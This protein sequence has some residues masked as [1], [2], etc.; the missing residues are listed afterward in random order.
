M[1]LLFA[2][3]LIPPFVLV[4]MV[5]LYFTHP[6]LLL[7]CSIAL[8]MVRVFEN[9]VVN[10][11]RF[12]GVLCM[13]DKMIYLL[14][15]R[16][17]AISF[18]TS[19]TFN[20]LL[21]IK[22]NKKD[23]VFFPLLSGISVSTLAYFLS[24]ELQFYV[25]PV[26][27]GICT[28]Y[29]KYRLDDT[30][31]TIFTTAVLAM[32]ISYVFYFMAGIIMFLSLCIP[33][34]LLFA[35]TF[36]LVTTQFFIAA[37]QL[38]LNILFYSIKRF[39]NGMSFLKKSQITN[40][41]VYVGSMILICAMLISTIHASGEVVGERRYIFLFPVI[42][43]LFF[44]IY[45]WCKHRLRKQYLHQ[46]REREYKRLEQQHIQSLEEI[47]LLREENEMLAKIVHRDNKLIPSMQ[48]S[49]EQ[50]LNCALDESTEDTIR[51]GHE[52]LSR[53]A[54]ERNER[55]GILFSVEQKKPK[56]PT[57]SI[58]GLDD[59]LQYMWY[60]CEAENI[61]VI[62]EIRGEPEPFREKIAS[63]DL[64][65]ICADLLENARIALKSC[66]DKQIFVLIKNENNI[67]MLNVWDNAPPFPKEV[68]YH[69]GKKRYTTHKNEG[70]SGIGI[71]TIWELLE[72]Y[73]ASICIDENLEGE[74][75]YT[76]K[77]EISFDS[78]RNYRLHTKRPKEECLF[79]SG[80]KDL[81]II[82]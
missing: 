20:R 8:R 64:Q 48:L 24:A 13:N 60:K 38:F 67:P 14:L 33:F 76:K 56:L 75:T 45:I 29:Y 17:L 6:P 72:H 19:Y 41:G 3:Y 25:V 21:H 68:L 32:S 52:L 37:F 42:I 1:F 12:F 49:V 10:F 47:K 2:S 11:C 62:V 78:K 22:R 82:V 39:K 27:F 35:Y 40:V 66:E 79:L 15:I 53:L 55:S 34:Y 50:Y 73:Q 70:G 61:K 46:V 74:T 7:L 81:E 77:V 63:K 43:L 9:M 71:I 80:R 54:M 4:A 69:F 16:Y 28:V 26:M 18:C 58:P 57:T 31:E 51:I 59:C 5:P 44:N 36:D 30:V 23:N 65:T